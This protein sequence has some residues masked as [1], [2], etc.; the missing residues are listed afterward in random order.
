MKET[1]KRHLWAVLAVTAAA[2]VLTA[3]AG[4]RPPAKP[5]KREGVRITQLADRLRVE[6]GGQLFTEYVFKDTPRPYC[7]PIIG[8]GGVAMT[9]DFPMRETPGED[10]DHKHHRSLWFAHGSVNGRDFWSEEKDFGRTVHRAFSEI[11]SGRDAGVIRSA[12][13]WI[14]ADG[15]V[16][17]T[18]ERTLRFHNG[19]ANERVVDFEITIRA[20]RGELTLGDTKEGTMSL[21]LAETMRLKPNKSNA[22]KPTGHIVN[23]E[24]VRDG[25]TWG[26]RAAWCDYYGPVDGR[27]VGVA[28]FDHPKNP[29]HPTWWHV[30]DYGLF[31]ANPFGQHDFEKLADKNAGDLVVP[32]GKSV[33][34]RYRFY[35]HEG[36]EQQARVAGR[37]AEFIQTVQ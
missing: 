28:I 2:L 8:P 25:E 33:T 4:R 29:R 17:C 36:D 30:R 12:N 9:R 16:I 14:A 27:T 11:T 22:G 3:C 13:D 26:K 20:S 32:A 19:P 34:F 21:R 15:A 5:A 31:A 23:S 7:H 1:V 24:G 35:F 18:D 37:Y 6:I 10:R